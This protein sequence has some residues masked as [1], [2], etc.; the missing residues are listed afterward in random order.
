MTK[1]SIRGCTARAALLLFGLAPQPAWAEEPATS[2][3]WA[4]EPEIASGWTCVDE[5]ALAERRGGLVVQDSAVLGNYVGSGSRTGQVAV[6]GGAFSDT[7]GITTNIINTGNNV[8]IQSTTNV[9]V[10]LD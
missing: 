1:L 5:D 8:S 7:R 6:S 10:H 4:H 9:I 2:A 3:T